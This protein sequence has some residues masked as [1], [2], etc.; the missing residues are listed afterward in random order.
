LEKADH[1][2]DELPVGQFAKLADGQNMSQFDTRAIRQVFMQGGRFD[3][4]IGGDNRYRDIV[5]NL[6]EGMDLPIP[7]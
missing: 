6:I 5:K 7:E 3:M 1:E 2:A 4:Q